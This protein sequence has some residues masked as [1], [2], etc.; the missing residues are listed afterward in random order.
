MFHLRVNAELRAAGSFRVRIQI[1][2]ATISSDGGLLLYRE[3]AHPATSSSL[4]HR[5]AH[6]AVQMAL[7]PLVIDPDDV[8]EWTWNRRILVSHGGL[9]SHFGL[10]SQSPEEPE[11]GPPAFNQLCEKYRTSSCV[12]FV[13]A[14]EIDTV[15]NFG[16]SLSAKCAFAGKNEECTK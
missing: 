2:A 13:V 9:V 12:A 4:L 1:H 16:P 3:L 14:G 8:V 7:D 15:A 5:A 10:I 11:S 6:D